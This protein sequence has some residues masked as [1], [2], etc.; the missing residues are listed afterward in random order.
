MA[1]SVTPVPIPQ[2]P[3]PQPQAIDPALAVPDTS[4]PML[5]VI[6][7]QPPPQVTL[8]SP[9]TP[10]LPGDISTFLVLI[11]LTLLVK[12]LTDKP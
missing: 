10:T 9:S 4:V 7:V 6:Q 11:A 3:I 2:I 1:Q 5:P 8:P 12:S